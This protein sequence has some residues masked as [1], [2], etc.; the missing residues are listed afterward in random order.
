MNRLINIFTVHTRRK[1]YK[2]AILLERKKRLIIVKFDYYE[3]FAYSLEDALMNVRN[4][5]EKRK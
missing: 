1:N 3:G 2:I 5:C 4:M